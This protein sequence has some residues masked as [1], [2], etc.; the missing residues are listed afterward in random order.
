MLPR[1]G[2]KFQRW[3]PREPTARNSRGA[4]SGSELD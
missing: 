3:L 2:D 4:K 1:L